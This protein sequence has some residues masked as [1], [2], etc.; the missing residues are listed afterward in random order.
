MRS[1]KDYKQI[2]R[3][4]MLWPIK[5]L[6]IV[7]KMN[8]LRSNPEEVTK[9]YYF[10][11]LNRDLRL[12][13]PIDLNEKIQWLKLYT[14][15]TEWTR[16]SDKVLVRDYIKSK[17]LEEILVPIYGVWDSAKL[18]DFASLPEKFV[19]KTNHGSGTVIVCRSK[20]D[21]DKTYARYLLGNWMRMKYGAFS[22]E[23]HYTS[24][25]PLIYAEMLL[26]N[27][28]ASISSSIIDY[29]IFCQDG[30]PSCIW[31]CANRTAE[32]VEVATYDLQWNFHPEWSAPSGHYKLSRRLFEKP[33]N[34]ERML[35]IARILSKDFPQV[36]VDLYNLDGQIYFGELT[37]T[38]AGGVMDFFTED[39]LTQMGQKVS[40][41]KNK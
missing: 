19:L 37:F 20:T 7:K 39:W 15:T 10:K 40:L 25:K 6:I 21:L 2:L 35:Q 16:L 22:A 18:V 12:T 14:D 4:Y 17:G 41:P 38:S 28:D 9:N 36:R 11:I 30:E 34:F 27:S 13:P 32:S 33:K 23:L 29:K 24:I 8:D 31:L 26:E 3:S 1:L 5:N